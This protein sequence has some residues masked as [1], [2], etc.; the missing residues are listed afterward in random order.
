MV[1]VF[2]HIESRLIH[3][4][5]VERTQVCTLPSFSQAKSAYEF[6]FQMFCY[7]KAQIYTEQAEKCNQVCDV[8]ALTPGPPRFYLL[9]LIKSPVSSHS[10]VSSSF[11]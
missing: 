4:I 2:S 5:K 6:L 11:K 3:D 9:H 8:I 10:Q 1:H 7:G